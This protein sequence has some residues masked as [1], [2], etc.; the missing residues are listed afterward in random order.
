MPSKVT[1]LVI[2]RP[3]HFYFRPGDYVFVNIPAIAK[4]EWHPF[5]LSS[6]PEQEDY[7]WLHIRGVGEWT[8]RLYSYFEREQARLHS[9]EVCPQIGSAS[10]ASITTTPTMESK[11]FLDQMGSMRPVSNTPQM[12]FLA[13]NLK[14]MRQSPMMAIKSHESQAQQQISSDATTTTLTNENEIEKKENPFK[15][16][17][18]TITNSSSAE[19]TASSGGGGAAAAKSM[20]GGMKVERQLSAETSSAIKKL[21][22]TLQR[23]F[24]RKGAQ[25][26]DGYTN[27]GFIG[28]DTMMNT[29][30]NKS[31]SVRRQ[32]LGNERRG[33]ELGFKNKTPL[34]KSL[35]MPDI[36]NRMRKRDRLMALREYN[37][38][39]SERSFDETQ[40]KKARMKSLG[41]AYLSPQNRSLAQ[42]FRYMR[43]K[44]TII[45]FKTPSLENCEQRPSQNSM[46]KF[47]KI[48]VNTNVSLSFDPKSSI[49]I[50]W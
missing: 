4:Y 27:D 24:S 13:K 12:D 16:D 43:N 25:S 46:S 20:P 44:P 30:S 3:S 33:T 6:A 21:Q 38:S 5:T 2:K 14:Q 1:H 11:K 18:A 26:V 23:T 41:L 34:E 40:M 15:F 10:S 32:K 35:S 29:E 37:R 49:L 36:E 19:M 47:S 39:E 28:D 48:Q 7:M 50:I 45:A 17:I 8:N 22:A 9:G 42:S 31:I